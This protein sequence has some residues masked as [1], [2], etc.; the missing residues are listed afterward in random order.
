MS[1]QIVLTVDDDPVMRQ[2]IYECLSTEYNVLVASDGHEGIE[3]AEAQHPDLILLDIMMPG[4]DGFSTLMLLKENELTKDIP[5][6]MLTAVGK[7]EKI[8]S[9]FRDGAADYLL[10]PFK[11]DALLAKI[12]SV[13][14]RAEAEG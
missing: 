5:I 7:K 10:K 9:A 12:K 8:L 2:A 14:T 4:F 6:I 3:L 1:R 11:P 13:L